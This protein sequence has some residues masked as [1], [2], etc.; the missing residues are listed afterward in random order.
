MMVAQWL[1]TLGATRPGVWAIKHVVAPLDRL[2]FRLS[3]GRRTL[4]RGHAGDVVLL[5]TMGRKSGQPR[6]TP[7][8]HLRDGDRIVLCNVNPGFEKTNPWVLNLRAQPLATVE[9]ET[10]RYWPQLIVIWPAYEAHF[11]RSGQRT[12]FLLEPVVDH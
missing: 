9:A 1:R 12:I 6:T 7:V 5:T 3:G 10:A 11:Q 2:T 4:S 8:F